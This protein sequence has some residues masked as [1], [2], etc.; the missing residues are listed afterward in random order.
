MSGFWPIMNF[1][2]IAYFVVQRGLYDPSPL[3]FI[4]LKS[5]LS[6]KCELLSVYYVIEKMFCLN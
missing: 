6:V 4:D 3:V 5:L 2:N 1:V